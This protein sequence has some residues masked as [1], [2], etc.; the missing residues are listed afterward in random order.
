MGL[1]APF[2]TGEEGKKSLDL[3]LAMEKA[4]LTGK[5]VKVK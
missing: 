1:E 5:T 4:A 2:C 3:V